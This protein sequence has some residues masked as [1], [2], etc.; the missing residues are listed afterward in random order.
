MGTKLIWV[1]EEQAARFEKCQSDEEK[2]KVF[3]E[4]LTKITEE[5]KREFKANLE[6]LEEDVAIYTGLMLKV[7]QAFGKAK[8]EQLTASY[9]IW[10]NFEKEMPSMKDNIGKLIGVLDPLEAKLK[11]INEQLGKINT[12]NIEKLAA[13]LEKFEQLSG[14]NKEMFDFVIKHFNSETQNA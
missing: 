2:Y 10:E 4:Y 7:K 8:D 9:A 3:E 11:T 1:N 14:R 5:S 13:T 12:W 6:N